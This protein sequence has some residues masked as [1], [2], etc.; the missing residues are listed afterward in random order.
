MIRRLNIM[1]SRNLG[2]SHCRLV[3]DE[4]SPEISLNYRLSILV[5]IIFVNLISLMPLIVFLDLDDAGIQNSLFYLLIYG[6]PVLLLVNFILMAGMGP[7]KRLIIKKKT[8][9][10]ILRNRY[11]LFGLFWGNRSIAMNQIGSF[12]IEEKNVYLYKSA[13]PHPVTNLLLT[14]ARGKIRII[15]RIGIPGD[16]LSVFLKSHTGKIINRH[17]W[18]V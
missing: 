1:K 11:P 14:T 17:N 18:K 10:V 4:Y 5:Q 15:T 8:N 3:E 7:Q 13:I 6:F 9:R 2:Y 16:N 12:I